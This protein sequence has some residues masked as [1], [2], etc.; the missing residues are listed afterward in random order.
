[1]GAELIVSI[2]VG[3]DKFSEAGLKRAKAHSARVVAAAKYVLKHMWDAD[4]EDSK[5]FQ[6]KA[7]FLSDMMQYE[8]HDSLLNAEGSI[9]SLS[10]LKPAKFVNEFHQWWRSCSGRDTAGRSFPS[11]FT[12][13]RDWKIVVCGE[14][15]GGQSP[16]GE[17]WTNVRTAEWLGIINILGIK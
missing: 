5:K 9:E 1:M 2:L 14:T 13:H 8:G 4:S 7:A 11:F 15:S 6:E 17:G 3:P 16:D 10:L 12:N